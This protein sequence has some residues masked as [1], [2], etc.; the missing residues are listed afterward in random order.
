MYDTH[1]VQAYIQIKKAYALANRSQ[2]KLGTPV[3]QA[4]LQASDELLSSKHEI[5]FA[6]EPLPSA[7]GITLNTGINESIASRA[8]EILGGKPGQYQLV[9]PNDHVNLNQEI[10]PLF[11]LSATLAILLALSELQTNLLNLERLLLRESL[12]LSRVLKVRVILADP[13]TT[14]QWGKRLNVFAT[15]VEAVLNRLKESA[16]T[17]IDLES[18]PENMSV[19]ALTK[20]HSVNAETLALA[21]LAELTGF[22]LKET[23]VIYQNNLCQNIFIIS[24]LL[25]IASALKDLALMLSKLASIAKMVNSGNLNEN[26]DTSKMKNAADLLV[27]SIKMSASLA[28]SQN[29]SFTFLAQNEQLEGE[30]LMPLLTNNLLG[31][32][33]LLQTAVLIITEKGLLSTS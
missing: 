31:T 6:P 12:T 19:A 18:S 24:D 5:K 26:A 1:L 22:R 21:H 15:A 4:I 23:K 11:N 25:L 9:N 16:N 8:E 3:C 30:L 32:I 13:S 33:Y 29:L 28:I 14:G 2:G 17:L 20:G 10:T 27:D 7:S